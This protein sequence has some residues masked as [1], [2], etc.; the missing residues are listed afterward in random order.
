M[1]FAWLVEMIGPQDRADVDCG[2]NFQVSQLVSLALFQ[3]HI[4]GLNELEENV[5]VL[6]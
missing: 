1:L 3:Q 6:L 2:I 5:N 4:R